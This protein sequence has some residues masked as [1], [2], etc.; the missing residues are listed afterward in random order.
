MPNSGLHAELRLFKRLFELSPNPIWILD[1]EHMVECNNAAF[2]A[3]GY[4][5]RETFLGLHTL[6]LSPPLQDDGEASATKAQRMMSIARQQG[7]HEFEWTL[8][9][10]DGSAM[11]TAVTLLSIDHEGRSIMYCVWR[12]I[13]EKQAAE[14]ALHESEQLYRDVTNNGQALIWLAGLDKS[15][16]YFNQPWLRFTGRTLAQEYGNGWTEGVHPDDFEHCLSTYVT[17]FDRREQF[18]MD[19]RLRRHDGEFRWIRDNGTPRYD[20]EG[21]F[22]GYI[23]HCLDITDRV[24]KALA[25]GK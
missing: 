6:Q 14:K 3:M 25:E 12:D 23:G 18:S 13:T 16:F 5:S 10:A 21:R 7:R 11:V 22:I 1:G 8:Q 17:A 19:Y 2:M 4:D 20:S 9:R 15:C 24:I